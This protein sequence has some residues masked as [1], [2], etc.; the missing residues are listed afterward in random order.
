MLKHSIILPTYPCGVHPMW[1]WL[2]GLSISL[3]EWEFLLQGFLTTVQID[4]DKTQLN[5]AL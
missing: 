4:P 2:S 3:A 5:Q 1:T